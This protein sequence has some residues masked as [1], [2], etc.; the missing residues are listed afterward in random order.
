M[1]P[2]VPAAVG[3]GVVGPQIPGGIPLLGPAPGVHPVLVEAQSLCAMAL[4]L[5]LVGSLDLALP[6]V[7]TGW[8]ACSLS[9]P[10]GFGRYRSHSI[11]GATE[12]V[13][14]PTD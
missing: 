11:R 13:N 1:D 12:W 5:C 3:H 4:A 8:L 6:V 14:S 10:H 2:S 9:M 7:C